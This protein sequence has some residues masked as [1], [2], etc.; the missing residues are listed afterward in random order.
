[1]ITRHLRIIFGLLYHLY[2][3]LSDCDKDICGRHKKTGKDYILS[4]TMRFDIARL[5]V[6]EVHFY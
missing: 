6:D 4:A 3:G 1:M 5:Y 2:F